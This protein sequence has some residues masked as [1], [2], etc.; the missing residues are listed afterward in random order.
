MVSF[1]DHFPP[2][3]K[4]AA[5][6]SAI[7]KNPHPPCC[8]TPPEM[9]TPEDISRLGLILSDPPEQPPEPHDYWKRL[10]QLVRAD[11]FI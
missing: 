6:E 7:R 11:K 2:P 8:R 4:P 5:T 1:P 3:Q 10:L 9:T